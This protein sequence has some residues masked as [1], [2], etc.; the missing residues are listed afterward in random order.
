MAYLG[1]I[2]VGLRQQETGQIN[3]AYTSYSLQATTSRVTLL[4]DDIV[5][6][7]ILQV[8]LVRLMAVPKVHHLGPV[9]IR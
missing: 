2:A 8:V 5:M 4:T 7:M 6:R 3:K 9:L 1:A